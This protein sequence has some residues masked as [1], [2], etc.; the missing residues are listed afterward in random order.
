MF[1]CGINTR[2]IQ[3]VVETVYGTY[4]SHA[5]IARLTRVA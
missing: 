2:K 4:Y 5:S 3:K 1:Q